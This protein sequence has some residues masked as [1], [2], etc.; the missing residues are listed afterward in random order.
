MPNLT[1]LQTN[2][3]YR[4]GDTSE[5]FVSETELIAYYN[6]ALRKIQSEYDY[7]WASR[8]ATFT[9]TDGSHVYKLSA[10]ATD[11]KNPIHL[12][13]NDDYI[14]DYIGPEDFYQLSASSDNI[15]SVDNN[16][17][18]V[19]TKFGSGSLKLHYYSYYTALT[20][21]GSDLI[22]LSSTTDVPMMPTE[23][24]DIL[25]DYA[26]ARVFQKEGRLDDYKIT[27]DEYLAGLK[28]LRTDNP[29]RRN[30]ISRRMQ[31]ISEFGIK[32]NVLSRKADPLRQS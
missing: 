28:K 17:L 6:E 12:F 18:L 32:N 27:H 11:F 19:Q 22:Q 30:R 16:E 8:Y 13:Y 15:Y 31:H 25:V 26:A 29:S 20:S 14:F 9:Y 2:T 7:E 4:F 1:T 3:R 10:I 24:H 5:S 21:G 23:Y